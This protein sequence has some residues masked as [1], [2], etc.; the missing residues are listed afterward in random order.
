[1]LEGPGGRNL[2]DSIRKR[3][4]TK[5]IGKGNR[6]ASYMLPYNHPYAICCVAAD[7]E[8]AGVAAGD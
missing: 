8:F 2:V 4:G 3:Y 5:K 1:V 6:H 7:G